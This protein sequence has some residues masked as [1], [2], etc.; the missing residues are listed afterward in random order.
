M[1]RVALDQQPLWLLWLQTLTKAS[2]A[3]ATPEPLHVPTTLRDARPGRYARID[4][5]T[6]P[7]CVRAVLM[8]GLVDGI[9]IKMLEQRSDG[10]CMVQLDDSQLR[11]PAVLANHIQCTV[12]LNTKPD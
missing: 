5:V 9:T 12:E 8:L 11:V 6:H 10:S 2:D 1:S 4:G 3:S 7:K